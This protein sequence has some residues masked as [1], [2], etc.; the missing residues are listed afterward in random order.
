MDCGPPG[1]A[2]ILKWVAMPSSRRSSWPRDQ[3]DVSYV[4]C[5]GRQV[6]YPLAPPS[7]INILLQKYIH[8]NSFY[9]ILTFIFTYYYLNT[10]KFTGEMMSTKFS[11]LVLL[12]FFCYFLCF[13]PFFP[14][15]LSLV[16]WFYWAKISYNLA[17]FFF[18]FCY[19]QFHY[20]LSLLLFSAITPGR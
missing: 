1:Q 5:I 17:S 6:L 18:F 14:F 2:R 11:E 10:E 12:I 20:P 13:F 19:I 16:S 7:H 8:T 9:S 3:I 15:S 4:S